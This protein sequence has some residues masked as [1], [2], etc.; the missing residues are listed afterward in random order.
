MAGGGDCDQQPDAL[1]DTSLTT[2]LSLSPRSTDT[3]R[4]AATYAFIKAI[5]RHR[6]IWGFNIV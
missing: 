5:Q 4:G 2:C 1:A 6:K 3:V